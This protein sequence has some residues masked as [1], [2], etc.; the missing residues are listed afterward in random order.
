MVDP[1]LQNFHGRVGRIQRIHAAGG[2]FEAAGTLGMFYYNTLRKRRRKA[3]WIAP[4][5]LV[6][7][8]VLLIK[9]G[10]LAVIGQEFYD[11]RVAMLQQ[12]NIVDQ[13]GAYVLQAGQ[14]T[15]WLS[16]AIRGIIR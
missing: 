1:N 4:V 8:T 5:V 6:M 2:G 12:G 3:T 10:V 9:A 14:T 11:D 7:L 15:V 13:A 16:E